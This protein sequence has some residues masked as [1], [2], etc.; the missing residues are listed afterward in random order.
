MLSLMNLFILQNFMIFLYLSEKHCI[1]RQYCFQIK[2]CSDPEC[3]VAAT[4]E[5]PWLPDPVY[6]DQNGGHYKKFQ[7]VIGTET[8]EKDRPSA[9]KQTVAA[10]AKEQQVC[11]F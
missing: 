5:R 7:D 9:Q 1:E 10:V 3:C 2:R 8:T 6:S 11:I 4:I